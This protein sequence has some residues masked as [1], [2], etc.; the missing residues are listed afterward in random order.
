MADPLPHDTPSIRGFHRAYVARL[1]GPVG[2]LLALVLF[3]I[4]LLAGLVLL[5]VSL[6][7]FP[8]RRART[9]TPAPSPRDASRDAALRRLVQAMAMDSSFTAEDARQAGTLA[10]GGA[11]VDELLADARERRWIEVAEGGRFAVTERG[12]RESAG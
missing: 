9:W 4:A 8:R 3:P 7:P 1:P 11:T 2:C 10:A 12:R 6:L 5:V